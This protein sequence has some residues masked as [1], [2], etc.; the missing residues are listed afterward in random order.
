MKFTFSTF[1][2]CALAG[3]VSAQTMHDRARMVAILDMQ[4]HNNENDSRLFSTEQLAIAAGVPYRITNDVS[5]A[6]TYGYILNGSDIQTSSFS[7]SEINTLDSYVQDGGVI[8]TCNMRDNRLKDVFGVNGYN[9]TRTNH[10]MNWNMNTDD[11]TLVWFDHHREQEIVLGK[12][13]ISEI[14]YTRHYDLTTATPLAFFDNDLNKPAVVV[15]KY[16]TGYA[17]SIG[18]S[19]RDVSLRNMLNYDYSTQRDYSNSFEPNADVWVLFIRAWYAKHQ[20]VQVWKHT[21]PMNSYQTV[22]VTHDID[23]RTGM[24]TM[25]LFSE[26]EK[27]QGIIADYNITT[28]Y[29]ADDVMSDFYN[30]KEPK[31]E[32]VKLDGHIIN[33]HSVGHF[34]DFASFSLGTIDVPKS[35]YNPFNDGNS[36]SGGTVF[37]E[38]QVSKE[39]LEANHNVTVKTFRAGHLAYPKTLPNALDSLGYR[40]DCTMSTNDMGYSFPF[41]IRKDRSFSGDIS[42]VYEVGMTVSDV[43]SGLSKDNYPDAVYKWT[44]STQ[45]YLN[46]Y[47]PVSLLIH[48]NRQYKLTAQ[49]NY[50]NQL[51]EK[52]LITHTAAYGDYWRMRETVDFC[53]QVSN[54]T[55]FITVPTIQTPLHPWMSFM[56]EG[57]HKIN[58]V[59]VRDEDNHNNLGFQF[60]TVPNS[61]RI[62][63]FKDEMPVISSSTEHSIENKAYKLYPNPSSGD[64]TIEAINHH[65][66]TLIE[67]FDL[68]GKR[69]HTEHFT[70]H[71][72]LRLTHLQG[73]FIVRLTDTQTGISVNEKLIIE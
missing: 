24:D 17:Y 35:N 61:N 59:I 44:Y 57:A 62:L 4:S 66:V 45:H 70:Q 42:N 73:A 19:L 27:N 16:G 21:S 37:P 64:V 68:S 56:A 5:E 10:T 18:L 6:V 54:D 67:I 30:G 23:S 14:I 48:P 3:F 38:V 43:I 69:V 15:N 13:T 11:S 53:T 55:L 12:S 50:V 41:P 2:L 51:S 60:E 22:M 72:Q 31:V 63:I 32:Q 39:L 29:F 58:E 36:T 47:S 7:S 46:N 8:L 49:I 71:H 28:R 40:Y 26:W 65:H 20:P 1:L 34:R 52:A 25:L 9:S 33:S